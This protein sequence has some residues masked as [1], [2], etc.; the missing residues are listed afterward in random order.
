MCLPCSAEAPC[1][2]RF[3]KTGSAC[4][5]I[6]PRHNLGAM[7][8]FSETELKLKKIHYADIRTMYLRAYLFVV[9]NFAKPREPLDVSGRRI[10][11]H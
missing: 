1:L 7:Q 9:A 2:S 4:K 3:I 8:D 10:Q 6:K 5:T 11:K